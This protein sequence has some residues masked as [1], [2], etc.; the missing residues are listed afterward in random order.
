MQKCTAIINHLS[1]LCTSHSF[2]IFWGAGI[3]VF[4]IVWPRYLFIALTMRVIASAIDIAIGSLKAK[5]FHNDFDSRI[6]W[7]SIIKRSVVLLFGML[8][9]ISSW[10]IASIIDQETYKVIVSILPIWY[11][12]LFTLQ[13]ITSLLEQWTDIDPNNWAVKIVTKIAKAIKSR[14]VKDLDDKIAMK[15]ASFYEMLSPW[16][17][18]NYLERRNN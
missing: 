5:F 11:F 10:H 1:T 8:L 18:K 14:V 3:V 6:F 16:V 17:W 7:K 12:H 13:E 2:E 4:Y 9:I 15:V